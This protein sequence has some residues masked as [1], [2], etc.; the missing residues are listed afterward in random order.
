MRFMHFQQRLDFWHPQRMLGNEATGT[1]D[2]DFMKVRLNFEQDPVRYGVP[3]HG[4]QLVKNLSV[5]YSLSNIDWALTTCIL[6]S[7]PRPKFHQM[8]NDL[9]GRAAVRGLMERCISGF[10]TRSAGVHAL[11]MLRKDGKH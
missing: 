2:N 4:L 10:A 8:P 1:T 11:G 3:I 6:E 5:T 7:A 9:D